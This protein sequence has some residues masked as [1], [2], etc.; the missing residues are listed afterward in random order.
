M[1][2]KFALICLILGLV[3]SLTACNSTLPAD[4]PTV[5]LEAA[6]IP[7]LPGEPSEQP[8][9]V[10][11]TPYPTTTP[12]QALIPTETLVEI[13]VSPLPVFD[14]PLIRRLAMC[15]PLQGWAL[16]MDGKSCPIYRGW[17]ADLA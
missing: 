16:T 5:T 8:P 10:E 9:A 3:G 17:R 6:A 4:I 13:S 7:E 12:E 1:K 11:D 15:T 2:T 14:A